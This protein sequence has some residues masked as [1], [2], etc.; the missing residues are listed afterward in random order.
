[1]AEIAPAPIESIVDPGPGPQD[2]P[3][4]KQ[5]TKAAAA[6]EPVSSNTPEIGVPEEAEKHELDEM[7]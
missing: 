7:A 4:H 6:E 2:Q 5:R 3:A 1:M